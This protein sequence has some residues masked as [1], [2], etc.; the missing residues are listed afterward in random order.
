MNEKLNKIVADLEKSTNLASLE[1]GL[2]DG[3]LMGLSLFFFYY[4][5]FASNEKYENLAYEILEIA[6]NK[7]NADTINTIHPRY[8]V[9][10]G[11]C[12]DFLSKEQFIEIEPDFFEDIENMIYDYMQYIIENEAL[13]FSFH[14]GLIGQCNYFILHRGSKTEEVI[15]ITLDQICSAFAIPGFPKHSVETVFLMPSETLQDVKFFL[16]KVERLKIYEEQI[17]LLKSH[18]DDFEKKHTILQSNCPEYYSIQY[19]REFVGFENKIL[20]KNML[21]SHAVY[22][23]DKAIWGLTYMYYE[24]SDLPNI[25]KIF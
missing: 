3:G 13:N 5:R 7:I 23:E 18:I 12:I 22:L 6:L 17:S 25:W 1:L 2:Y 20:S 4:S 24:K 21:D 16:R 19:F 14:E 8:L 10:V 15:K 9:Q 11:N